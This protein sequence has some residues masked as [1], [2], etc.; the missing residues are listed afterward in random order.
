MEPVP[1]TLKSIIDDM[2]GSEKP[3]VNIKLADLSNVTSDELAYLTRNWPGVQV[4]Q[5]RKIVSRLV[6]LAEENFELNFDSIFKF[7]LRDSDA[8]V[9][10]KAIEG[11]WECEEPLLITYFIRMLNEDSSE[12]V[13]A[14]AAKALRKYAML[15]EIKK[16]GPSSSQRVSQALIAI[17]ADR[18]KPLEVWRRAL[19]AAAPLSLAEIKE[20]IN[21]AYRQ[22]DTKLKNSALYAMGR[23]CDSAWLPILI[24][25][26]SNPNPETRYEAAGACGE[27]CDEEAV[28]H[29]MRMV[30]DKDAEVQQAAILA[31]GKIG[32]AKAEA[33][34][35]KCLKSS[36]EVI[37]DTAKQAI[38][39]IEAESDELF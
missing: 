37:S 34:L 5:R 14:A 33:F 30:Q 24:K 36:D 38:K 32:G 8:E 27:I 16:L 29:L 31:L 10:A 1:G 3:L 28:P 25:E 35:Q 11:L 15:A 4:E 12:A 19:E 21:Y 26:L 2:I 18:K 7:A 17:L 23:N 9:R 13:Q 6:E 22:T 39:Q 20:A